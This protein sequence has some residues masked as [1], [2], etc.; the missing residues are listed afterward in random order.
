M[1]L[2]PFGVFIGICKVIVSISGHC[3]PFLSLFLKSTDFLG[4]G[5]FESEILSLSALYCLNGQSVI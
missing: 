5:C 1:S 4:L 3:L 2:F